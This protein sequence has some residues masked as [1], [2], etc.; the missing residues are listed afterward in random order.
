MTAWRPWTA[1]RI[2]CG[3]VLRHDTGPDH[4]RS[5]PSCGL[6]SVRRLPEPTQRFGKPNP[7]RL[8]SR[9]AHSMELREPDS[10]PAAVDIPPCDGSRV[11]RTVQFQ[12]DTYSQPSHAGTRTALKYSNVIDCE[13]LRETSISR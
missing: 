12:R 9:T 11:M 8:G 13:R 10:G 5:R 4:A 2:A 6:V 7:S 1:K 3:L